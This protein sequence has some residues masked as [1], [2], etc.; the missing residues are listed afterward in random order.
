MDST[1]PYLLRS[2][3]E[4]CIDSGYTPFVTVVANSELDIPM[5]SM[6]SGELVFNIGQNAV[7][8]LMIANDVISF[9]AR[10]NGVSKKIVLPI[11]SVKGIF[12]KEVNQGIAFQDNS[13]LVDNQDNAIKEVSTQLTD[14]VVSEEPKKNTRKKKTQLR[15]VK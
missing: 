3:Y 9:Y 2:I 1:K 5:D 11:E 6:N 7:Q 8:D 4:W 15:L 13:N 12:A 10:F 14:L